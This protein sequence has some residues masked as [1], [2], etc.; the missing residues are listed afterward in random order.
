MSKIPVALLCLLVSLPACAEWLSYKRTP[1]T[2]ELYDSAF[3][4]RE[5]KRVK[6]WTLTDYAK[7]ITSLEGQELLSEKALT[8]VDCDARK[9]GSE[10]V[11]KFT[12]AHG[13]GSLVG[14]METSLRLT[15][16][17]PGSA[18]EALLERVCR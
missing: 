13:K 2:D 18:D 3:V 16:V 6:L 11:L 12:E 1:D 14:A 10:K 4:S 5:G 15:T 17:R 8:T 7:P 9:V